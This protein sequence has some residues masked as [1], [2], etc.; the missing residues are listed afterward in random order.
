MKVKGSVVRL[1]KGADRTERELSAGDDLLGIFLRI[2]KVVPAPVDLCGQSLHRIQVHV[3]Y[4][5]VREGVGSIVSFSRNECL[6]LG[7]IF[8]S[9]SEI[10]KDRI[11]DLVIRV[12]ILDV[13]GIFGD[14]RKDLLLH[15]ILRPIRRAEELEKLEMRQ[16]PQRQRLTEVKAGMP[17]GV[18][19]VL[20]M[21]DD[22]V[23]VVDGGIG[24]FPDLPLRRRGSLGG[25]LTF[26]EF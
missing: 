24:G 1:H 25:H 3:R 8:L 12:K 4:S 15:G 10:R 22:V 20:G 21:L 11:V 18:D 23:D 13:K 17:V 7:E 9:P 6:V 5:R 19:V 14:V 16:R 26:C 2:V